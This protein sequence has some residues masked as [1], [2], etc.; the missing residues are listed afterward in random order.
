MSGPKKGEQCGAFFRNQRQD[1][2]G[3]ER[4]RRGGSR[5]EAC[6]RNGE[7]CPRYTAKSICYIELALLPIPISKAWRRKH[8]DFMQWFYATAVK[9]LK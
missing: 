5:Q 9:G 6:D 1:V 2:A 3:N 8:T 7:S 4:R